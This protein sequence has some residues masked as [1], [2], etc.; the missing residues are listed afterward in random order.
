MKDLLDF[1]VEH[2]WVALLLL[3]FVILTFLTLIIVISKHWGIF[4]SIMEFSKNVPILL[5][6]QEELKN[7]HVFISAEIKKIAAETIPNGT[8]KI[9]IM[10]DNVQQT[11]QDVKEIKEI[12]ELN[13]LEREALLEIDKVPTFKCDSKGFCT[14]ANASL[15]HLFETTQEQMLGE[16]WGS[17]IVSKDVERAFKNWHRMIESKGTQIEDEYRIKTKSGFKDIRYKA[18]AK[19]GKEGEILFVIGTIWEKSNKKADLECLFEMADK[20]SKTTIWK[21]AEQEIQ[22]HESK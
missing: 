10:F 8:N 14:F 1:L 9:R 5:K 18:I 20:F 13:S 11:A 4:S 3:T 15:C 17:F 2:S 16:G 7:Q 21:Q 12:Q 19:H 6:N 22:K